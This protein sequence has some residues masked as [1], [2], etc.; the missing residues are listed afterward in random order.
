M[1]CM[2]IFKDRSYRTGLQVLALAVLTVFVV[3][4]RLHCYTQPYSRDVT[5]YAVV[6]HELLNGKLLYAQIWDHK[7]PAIYWTYAAVEAIAGYGQ[8]GIFILGL[9]VCLGTLICIFIAGKAQDAVTPRSNDSLPCRQS[10]SWCA[11]T[12]GLLAGAVWVIAGNDLTMTAIEPN[13]EVFMNLLMAAAFALLVSTRKWLANR[14]TAWIV[15]ILFAAASLYKPV[16]LSTL[17]LLSV[18][19][20]LCPPERTSLKQWWAKAC[21]DVFSMVGAVGASWL[22]VFAYFLACGAR[23]DFNG[24]VFTYNRYYAGDIIQNLARACNPDILINPAL[25]F[26]LPLFLLCL[27]AIIL[28]AFRQARR[29]WLMLLGYFAG[30]CLA[31]LSPGQYFAHY[32]ELWVPPLA[33]GTG[34]SIHLITEHSPSRL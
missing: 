3:C 26:C 23:K 15:G 32:Y 2:A 1:D 4:I 29:R 24:A 10:N 13:T 8:A 30:T 20:I 27:V 31:V 12:S 14:R 9:L 19:H 7:P 17:A 21:I 6:G 33:I 5:T 22:C 18:V 11:I 25:Q 34:W 16:C 28:G